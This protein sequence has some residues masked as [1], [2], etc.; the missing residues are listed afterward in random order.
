MIAKSVKLELN[1]KPTKKF[2][3]S[4]HD[5]L[6]KAITEKNARELKSDKKGEKRVDSEVKLSDF[7]TLKLVSK[8]ETVSQLAEHSI[9]INTSDLSS[10]IQLPGIGPKTA[11]KIINLRNERKGYKKLD[12]LLDVKGIGLK[13]FDRIKKFLYIE[14]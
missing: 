9:N 13:K 5:S 11:S 10:L 14:K 2:D 3:Y 1:S 8:K 7:S 12:E 4:F 6:F